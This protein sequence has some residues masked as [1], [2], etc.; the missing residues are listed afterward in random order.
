MNETIAKYLIKPLIAGFIVVL[1]VFGVN[2][3]LSVGLGVAPLVV[4]YTTS[5]M[6]VIGAIFLVWADGIIIWLIWSEEVLDSLF[7]KRD[8]L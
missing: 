5:P 8:L 2:Y 3:I 6:T 7:G 4:T 1:V